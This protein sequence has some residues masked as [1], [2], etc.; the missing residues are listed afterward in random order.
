MFVCMYVT[1]LSNMAQQQEGAQKLRFRNYQPKH[2]DLY[3]YTAESRGAPSKEV[4][5]ELTEK[6]Q[7]RMRKEE[8][9]KTSSETQKKEAANAEF[10]QGQ[11]QYQDDTLQGTGGE[12]V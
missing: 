5:K 11:A 7:Q 10:F 12:K 6:D 8:Q 9:S 3:T 4:E 2:D 1:N